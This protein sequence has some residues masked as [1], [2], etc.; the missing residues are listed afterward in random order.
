MSFLKPRVK[1]PR[2]S[3]GLK[4]FWR[5]KMLYHFYPFLMSSEM[6]FE[7]KVLYKTRRHWIVLVLSSIKFIS[8][9]ALPV[10]I[11]TYFFSG[12]SF[13]WWLIGFFCTSLVLIIYDHYLWHHSWLIIGNQK[14][15]LSVRNGIFSQ[16]AMSI[17]YRNIRDCAV[18]K[19]SM[20]GFFLKYGSLF[21]RS[22]SGSDGDFRAY[23]VPKVGKV[24][25]LVNA[26]S[27]YTDEERAGFDTIE[28]LYAHHK[29]TEFNDLSSVTHESWNAEI[30]PLDRVKSLTWVTGAVMLGSDA[31]EYI[32]GYE[33]SRN[34]GVYDVLRKKH[35]L[36]LLHDDLF[37]VPHENLVVKNSKGEIYFP[38]LA[39]PQIQEPWAISASPSKEIHE[40]LLRYFPYAQEHEATVLV[41][42]DN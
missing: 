19:N 35:V 39:F 20:L 18:S 28:K 14:I 11:V 1:K 26:L 17:R 36:C 40:Y 2:L 4:K 29:W 27:R 41:G 42:W 21:I 9:V 3:L 16:Y 38:P 37:P 31:R 15:S 33:E 30:S 24:Y 12:F 8:I 23:H 34:H 13:G 22:S 7:E 32:S 6:R 25:A 5:W 10:G